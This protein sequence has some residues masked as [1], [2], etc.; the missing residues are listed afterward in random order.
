MLGIAVERAMPPRTPVDLKTMF[1]GVGFIIHHKVVLGAVLLDLFAVLLGNATAVL[2]IF[3]R[4]IFATGPL[5]F[6]LLRA[7][8]AAGAIMTALTLTRW[9][10]RAASAASCFRRSRIF[11]VGT[12]VLA[13]APNLCRGR[14]GDVHRRG[15]RHGQRRDPADHGADPHA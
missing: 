4:D 12:I 15:F 1:S 5:G 10:I 7:A 6:G 3:A 13:L 8:P 9:P 11:G 2:P 14:G